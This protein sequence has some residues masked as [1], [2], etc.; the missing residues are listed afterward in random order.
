MED[1]PNTD[2]GVPNTISIVSPDGTASNPDSYPS[3]TTSIN[4]DWLANLR[5]GQIIT[6]LKIYEVGS[7]VVKLTATV[8]DPNTNYNLDVNN[9]VVWD[10]GEVYYWRVRGSNV[11]CAIEN[12]VYS[13]DGYF[14]FKFGTEYSYRTSSANC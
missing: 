5:V 1:R 7:A 14:R 8:V 4:L 12:G 6:S 3:A 9:Q 10:R 13:A 11:D 2:G